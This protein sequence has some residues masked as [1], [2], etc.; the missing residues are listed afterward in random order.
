MNGRLDT[1]F[2]NKRCGATRIQEKKG[3]ALPGYADFVCNNKGNDWATFYELT[4]KD[5]Q[6]LKGVWRYKDGTKKHWFFGINGKLHIVDKSRDLKKGTREKAH[7]FVSFPPAPAVLMMPFVKIWHYRFNDVLFTLF[8]AAANVLL[9][10]LLFEKLTALGRSNRTLVENILL[11][12]LLGF[13]SSIFFSSVR[14][15]VWFTALVIGLTFNVLFIICSLDARHPVWAGLMLA[16]AVATRVP[17]AF[18]CIFFA[19]ELFRIPD[20]RRRLERAAW[21]ALPLLIMAG[22]LMWYNLARFGSPTEFGHT[23]LAYG[24]RASIVK[25]GLFSPHFLNA[26]L[27]AALAN[28]PI[29]HG[30][31]PYISLT[32]HGISIFAATP[33]LLFVLWPKRWTP[34]MTS[35]AA[36]LACVALPGL[37]YQN[38]G[39]EQFSY[40]FSIDYLP[41]LGIL[42]A[43]GD[44]DFGRTFKLACAA[45]FVI[46]AFGAITFNRYGVFYA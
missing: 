22:L 23:Y 12:M 16:L 45:S 44:R 19:L 39:W 11:A 24:Q 43:C 42:L 15:E 29:I 41:F 38:T 9:L 30:T 13:G 28:V 27:H 8:F 32:K 2:P 21:F 20:W 6:T 36:A 4:T 35:A 3:K 1:D 25:H 46:S 40:R 26:N 33:A 34:G 18:G 17:L 37:F 10:L 7:H 5:G 14:G 31:F